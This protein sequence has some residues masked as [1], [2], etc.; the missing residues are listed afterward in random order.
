MSVSASVGNNAHSVLP[1]WVV[2]GLAGFFGLAIATT[3]VIAILGLLGLFGFLLFARYPVLGVYATAAA[4][5]LQGSTGILGVVN[6]DTMAITLAQL[7]G[8]AALA[9]WA[10]N[11]LITR[12]PVRW[13]WPISLIIGFIIWSMIGTILGVAPGAQF[14][15]WMRLVTRLAFFILAVNALRTPKQM[16]H[17]VIVVLTCA[18]L[19]ALSA[20]SQYFIP[21]AQIAGAGDWASVGATDSAYIDQESLQGEAAI[22]VS[23]RAGH[24]NWLALILLLILPL[25]AYWFSLAKTSRM[26]LFI[27]FV[28][29]IEVAALV[30]TFT[31]TGLVIGCVVG[32][33]V[34]LRKMAKINT[35]RVF[36]GLAVLVIAFSMLP[37]AYK[38]RVLNPQQYTQSKSVMSRIDLQEA[39]A[40]YFIENPVFGLGQG[41][42]GLEFIYERNETAGIMKFMV[43]QGNGQAIFIGTHN[44]FLQLGADSG[45]IGLVHFLA[46]FYV[47]VKRLLAAEKRFRTEGNLQAERLAGA[48]VISLVGFVLCMV[49]LHALHQEVWWMIAAAAVALPM[50]DFNE[51][52]SKDTE[53][54]AAA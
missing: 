7:V 6:D 34:L 49:F 24:S 25:N 9:A 27:G 19:M 1:L 46:F 10:A 12:A 33:L 31:R 26:K 41:G 13:N 4:L 40:R 21:S 22:R 2:I 32:L 45:V 30:L 3:G 54:G 36:S 29:F 11:T 43:E 18:F 47:T 23:G 17:F 39:A 15:H 20:V 42:F 16:K 52:Q 44:M 50:I 51:G 8:I 35:L 14:P 48:L 37:G 28:I 53:Q 5:L 38:E